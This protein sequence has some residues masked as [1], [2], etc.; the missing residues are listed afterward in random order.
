MDVDLVECR[1]MMRNEITWWDHVAMTLLHPT[2]LRK[3]LPIIFYESFVFLPHFFIAWRGFLSIH[4]I[5]NPY[6]F[7]C[8]Y[9]ARNIIFRNLIFFLTFLFIEKRFF[10]LFHKSN[11]AMLMDPNYTQQNLYLKEKI[12]VIL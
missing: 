12:I 10:Y 6:Y 3:F 5:L 7:N 2:K 9:R 11:H 1:W 4:F 8:I